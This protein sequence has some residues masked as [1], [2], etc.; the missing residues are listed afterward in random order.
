MVRKSLVVI[1]ASL[2]AIS[3]FTGTVA[4][5]ILHVAAAAQPAA[6]VAFS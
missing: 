3:A 4:L 2:M 1:A 5:A 6:Q